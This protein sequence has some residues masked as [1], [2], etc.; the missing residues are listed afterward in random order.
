MTLEMLGISLTLGFLAGVLC[1]V[2]GFTAALHQILLSPRI[3]QWPDGATWLRSFMFA[4]AAVCLYF[5]V[6][7]LVNAEISGR[8]QSPALVIVIASDTLLQVA[9]LVWLVRQRGKAALQL[10]QAAGL[11]TYSGKGHVP[12]RGKGAVAAADPPVP[13]PL[14]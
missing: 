12:V 1:L 5:G 10:L 14:H 2:G 13:P 4:H 6:A 11:W 9:T 7:I 8:I 3:T